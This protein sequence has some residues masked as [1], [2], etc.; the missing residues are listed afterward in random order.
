MNKSPNLK[1]EPRLK[2]RGFFLVEALLKVNKY[3]HDS[4]MVERSA[5]RLGSIIGK[6]VI[7]NLSNSGNP[8]SQDVA[9]PSQA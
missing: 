6:P 8:L 4:S 2:S 1:K 7:E 9:I 3:F 5:V